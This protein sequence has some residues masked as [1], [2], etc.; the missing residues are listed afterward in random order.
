MDKHLTAF[1]FHSGARQCVRLLFGFCNAPATFQRAMD[2]LL[3][4][5]KLHICLAF[6]DDVIVFSC[7]PKEHIQHLDEV[8]TRLR[9]A[10]ITLKAAKCH[11]F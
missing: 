9:K 1:T 8:L 10:V 5:L 6:L 3:A 2:M 11:L 4:G 7:S